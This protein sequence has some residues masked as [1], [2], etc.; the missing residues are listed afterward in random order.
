[1]YRVRSRCCPTLTRVRSVQACED[2]RGCVSG[3]RRV[4]AADQRRSDQVSGG[5]SR[6][7]G[8]VEAKSVS[9]K[10]EPDMSTNIAFLFPGQGSQ[11]V[12]MGRALNDQ[13]PVAAATFQE[14]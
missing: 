3:L 6:F 9:S 7:E 8:I 11:T 5:T 10:I 2:S 14:A 12:G 1:M 4:Q 13:F